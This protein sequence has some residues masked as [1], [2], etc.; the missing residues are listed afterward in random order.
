MTDADAVYAFL[1]LRP[2]DDS[3]YTVSE[4]QPAGFEDCT[5]SAG[6]V[7]DVPSGAALNP[8]DDIWG[9]NDRGIWAQDASGTLRLIARKGGLFEVEPGDSRIIE[10]VRLG[11]FNDSGQLSFRL[12]FFDASAGLFIAG[13]LIPGDANEDGL[14]NDDDLS[15]LIA[16][17]GSETAAWGHGE[18]SGAPPVNDDDLSLLLANWTGTAPVPEPAVLSLLAAGGW[19]VIRR[20]RHL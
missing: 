10:D 19:A 14:V 7:N 5:G 18:F 9:G 11:G 17:W 15:L 3:G 16:H 13:V 2:S 1:D 6:T 8:G 4:D 12:G 20:R